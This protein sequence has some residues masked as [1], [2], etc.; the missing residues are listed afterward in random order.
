MGELWKNMENCGR[1]GQKRGSAEG[2]Q[3]NNKKAKTKI[4]GR[5]R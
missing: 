4:G 1:L 3:R 5:F 2:Y